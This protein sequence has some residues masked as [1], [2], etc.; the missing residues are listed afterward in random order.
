MLHEVIE[1]V[2]DDRRTIEEAVRCLKPGGQVVI[3][4]PNRLY[5]FETHGFY[6]LG[7]YYFKLLPLVNYLPDALRD[8]FCPHVRIY[9]GSDIRRLFQ[10]L[11]VSLRCSS[12][13]FPGLDNIAERYGWL[14]RTATEHRGRHR[15]HTNALLWHLALRRLSEE[16]N[17]IRS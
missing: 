15:E 4:A 6:F 11:P 16:R 9:R 13:I 12:Y 1:H 14:G 8:L 17:L 3:F 7:H 5:F 10:E 2:D